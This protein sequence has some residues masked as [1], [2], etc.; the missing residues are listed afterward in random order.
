MLIGFENN[1]M[2]FPGQPHTNNRPIEND[3]KYK[4]GHLYYSDPI[5][6]PDPN[7]PTSQPRTI[8]HAFWLSKIKALFS[9][10]FHSNRA[11]YLKSS[12]PD[13]T[14]VELTRASCHYNFDPDLKKN[15]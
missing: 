10:R 12:I 3:M 9:R 7:K 15:C 2:G 13:S 6:E 14:K 11:D 5:R 8:Y 4:A 1:K